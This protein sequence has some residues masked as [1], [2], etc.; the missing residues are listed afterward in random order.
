MLHH[1][2]GKCWL[3]HVGDV[4]SPLIDRARADAEAALTVKEHVNDLEQLRDSERDLHSRLSEAEMNSRSIQKLLVSVVAEKELL[5]QE[6]EELKNVCE[7][8]MSLAETTRS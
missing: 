7:E 5:A 6:N 2:L 1:T 3:I 8:A 4:V